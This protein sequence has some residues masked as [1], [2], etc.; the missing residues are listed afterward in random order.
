MPI[1]RA[2]SSKNMESEYNAK[3]R[4]KYHWLMNP[5][6]NLLKYILAPL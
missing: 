2:I 3:A 5:S 4:A 6:F 1:E